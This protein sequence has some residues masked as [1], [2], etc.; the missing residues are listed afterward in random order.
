MEKL[1]K[2]AWSFTIF[3]INVLL[4]LLGYHTIKASDKNTIAIGQN[5]QTQ[6]QPLSQAT[7]DAQNKITT[8]RENKLRNLNNSPKQIKQNQITTQTTTV[9]PAPA[10]SSTQTKTS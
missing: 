5:S 9:A 2:H 1:K 10:K 7:V 8:D 6:V 3:L 4:L